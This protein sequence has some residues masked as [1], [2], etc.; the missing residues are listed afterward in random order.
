MSSDLTALLPKDKHDT[1]KVKGIVALGFPAV[2]PIL[3]DLLEWMQ[4]VN[5]PVAQALLPFLA[6]IGGPLAPHVRHVLETDDEVWKYF[7]LSYIVVRSPEL[8]TML[9][10]DLERLATCPTRGEQAEELDMLAR[11]IVG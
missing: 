5:W 11:Q 10:A 2:E 7:V 8:Q 1:D 9:R 3:P 4:D 6:N